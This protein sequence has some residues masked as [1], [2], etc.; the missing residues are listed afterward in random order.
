[1]EM[2]LWDEV[3]MET[4]RASTH[5]SCSLERGFKEGLEEPSVYHTLMEYVQW[6][7]EQ[8]DHLTDCPAAQPQPL[9]LQLQ[10]VTC[11]LMC[12]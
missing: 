8:I 10:S 4:I 7:Q 6:I 9:L 12:R 1:M 5:S 11:K 3:I 2:V